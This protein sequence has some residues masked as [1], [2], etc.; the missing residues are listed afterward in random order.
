MGSPLL[1]LPFEITLRCNSPELGVRDAI[2]SPRQSC[3][4][5]VLLPITGVA[6]GVSEAPHACL[7]PGLCHPLRA[8]SAWKFRWLPNTAAYCLL[9]C[10]PSTLWYRVIGCCSPGAAPLLECF[11][12]CLGMACCLRINNLTDYEGTLADTIVPVKSN[13]L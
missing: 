13:C 4:W 3:L 1:A 5:G 9:L 7:L 2:C 6:G 10:V 8:R 11:P 12:A